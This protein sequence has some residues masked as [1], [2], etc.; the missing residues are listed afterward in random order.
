[1][2]ALFALTLMEKDCGGA[3]RSEKYPSTLTLLRVGWK[4]VAKRLINNLEKDSPT[5]LRNVRINHQ[6]FLTFSF[7]PFFHTGVEFEGHTSFQSQIIEFEPRAP[8]KKVDISGQ[9][10]IRLRL[11]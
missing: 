7:D 10:L 6:S 1:M 8:L 2:F 5:T 3:W 11:Q 9:I 4:E